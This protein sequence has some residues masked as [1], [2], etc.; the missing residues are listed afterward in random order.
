MLCMC[1]RDSSIY[2]KKWFL[3]VISLNTS[4]DRV[5]H[6]GRS[7]TV[8]R[9]WSVICCSY[10]IYE[11]PFLHHSL[12]MGHQEYQFSPAAPLWHALEVQ[13]RLIFCGSFFLVCLCWNSQQGRSFL[14]VYF[15]DVDMRHELRV[16]DSFHAGYMNSARNLWSVCAC[17]DFRL[18]A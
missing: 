1:I 5:R 6:G 8:Y 17:T 13:R 2:L 11:G 10:N 18:V 15:C 16:T 3:A 9:S 14:R 4:A 12:L 7:R